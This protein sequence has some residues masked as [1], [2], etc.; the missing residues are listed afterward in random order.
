[1]PTVYMTCG[2]RGRPRRKTL[3]KSCYF[4]SAQG[5]HRGSVKHVGK[6]ASKVQSSNW[7]GI[8]HV[9]LQIKR[10]SLLLQDNLLLTINSSCWKKNQMYI[11][12]H[13][14]SPQKK[15]RKIQRYSHFNESSLPLTLAPT[16]LH[17]HMTSK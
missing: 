15:D 11:D 7:E 4:S 13:S 16:L 10:S 6:A 8:V 9:D 12:H 17:R 14:H 5:S 3:D 1:M 2:R